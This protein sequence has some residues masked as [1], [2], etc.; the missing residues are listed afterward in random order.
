MNSFANSVFMQRC[1]LV[2]RLKQEK[3]SY[4]M[5]RQDFCKDF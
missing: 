2:S 5:Y 3:A 4:E 1:K